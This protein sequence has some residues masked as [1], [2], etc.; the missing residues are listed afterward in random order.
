MDTRFLESFITVVDNGSVAEAA[1][2]LNLTPA[3]VAKRVRALEGE[4]GARLVIR[5]GRTVR[6]TEAGAAILGRARDFLEE[7]R[8]LKS[9]AANDRP[10]GE[11]RVAASQSVLFGLL[12]GILTLLTK[13]YPEIE[14]HITRGA[15]A[16]I[17]HR[18]LD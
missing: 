10:S 4:I 7:A 15:A 9:I 18:L 3:G 1:R 8:D 13:K 12:P 6:P 14:V 17:Y 5:S 11:L 2:R 16:E